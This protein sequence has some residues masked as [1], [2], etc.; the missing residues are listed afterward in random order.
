MLQE[1]FLVALAQ[2]RPSTDDNS[3]TVAK[4][5]VSAAMG[6]LV[7][8]LDLLALH[9]PSELSCRGCEACRTI[10]SVTLLRAAD[11]M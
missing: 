9:I 5:G 2:Q 4:S 7:Q 10:I 1:Y 3:P 6:K 8:I 11:G